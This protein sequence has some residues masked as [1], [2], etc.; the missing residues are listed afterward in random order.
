MGIEDYLIN[1]YYPGQT[2]ENLKEKVRNCNEIE[3]GFSF[4]F[5]F[6][7]DE[8]QIFNFIKMLYQEGFYY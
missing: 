5:P 1:F 2:V 6:E 4:I 7:V 3:I 8:K